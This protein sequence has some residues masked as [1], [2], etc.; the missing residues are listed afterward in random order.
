MPSFGGSKDSY[1][2]LIKK[3]KTKKQKTNK[4]TKNQ[5]IL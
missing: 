2:V 5:E 3:Q 1:S 4:Q